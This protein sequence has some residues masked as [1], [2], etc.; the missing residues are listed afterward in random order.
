MAV[1]TVT[2]RNGV[3]AAV[4]YG[5]FQPSGKPTSVLL[6]LSEELGDLLANLALGHA[7]IVLGVTVGGHQV[8]EAIVR[9]VDLGAGLVSLAM[10]EFLVLG[11]LHTSV[12]SLR[13]TT[14]T[15]MLWVEGDRSS[16]FLPVKMSM[17]TRWTLA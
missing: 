1:W 10:L 13:L 15:S 3:L 12:Y 9:D 16:S 5:L 2:T 6:L 4:S 7:D 11:R 17:A 14:G 8:E